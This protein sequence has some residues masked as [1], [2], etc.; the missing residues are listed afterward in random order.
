MTS[1]PEAT[2]LRLSV[3]PWWRVEVR[4]VGPSGASWVAQQQV[5]AA[6]AAE[7]IRTVLALLQRDGRTVGEP[8]VKRIA[9]PAALVGSLNAGS[10]SHHAEAERLFGGAVG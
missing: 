4:I 9:A 7:A 3:D 10:T 8:Q 2:N 5:Q 6:D 1:R